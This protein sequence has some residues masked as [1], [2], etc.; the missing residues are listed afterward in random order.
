MTMYCPKET[1]GESGDLLHHLTILFR[2][3]SDYADRWWK[4]EGGK[5][6]K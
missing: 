4:A 3:T 5:Y 1:A 2:Q 6:L